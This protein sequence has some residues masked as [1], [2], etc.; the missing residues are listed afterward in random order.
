MLKLIFT[1]D[2]EIH[3]NGD[4]CAAELM[5][6]PTARILDLFDDFGAKLT[7]MADTVEIM[8]FREHREYSGQSPGVYGLIENQ[9]KDAARRGH[10]V[11]LH[12]HP[13][14]A[15]ASYSGGRWILD[16]S[17]YDLARLSYD[18]IYGLVREGKRFLEELLGSVRPGYRCLAFRAANW[19]MNPSQNIIRALLANGISID[20]SIF[21]YGKRDGL[22]RFDYSK[23]ES[24]MCPWPVDPSEVCRR[25]DT[26]ELFEFPIY[27]EAR[28]LWAFLSAA[29]F[30]RLRESWRHRFAD[31]SLTPDARQAGLA[32]GARARGLRELT[33]LAAWKFSSIFKK[34]AWK[35][36]FNQCSGRQMMS[37]LR[38]AGAQHRSPETDLPVV[39]IGHSKLYN[40]LNERQLGKFLRAIAD[41]PDEYSFGTFAEFDLEPFRR[42]AAGAANPPHG[43]AAEMSSV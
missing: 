27:C 32:V 14:Y 12:L 42:P 13:A 3:G 37:A 10:D 25:D 29:R 26:G 34:Y 19:S 39:C 43:P 21:K 9:L 18:R 30:R 20:T 36:D 40:N 6:S 35:L 7:I 33:A 5:V 22:V 23:A 15:H 17:E 1:L 38:R 4:G 2:Y 8:K 16:L 31:Q 24:H 11:Q 41:H 28:S